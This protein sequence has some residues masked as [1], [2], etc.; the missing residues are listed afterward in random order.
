MNL[1]LFFRS[2]YSETVRHLHH[3]G[4]IRHWQGRYLS[5]N[6]FWASQNDT[7][8]Q[9]QQQQLQP[10][11]NLYTYWHGT[12]TNATILVF[13]FLYNFQ[14]HC[15]ASKVQHVEEAVQQEWFRNVL[16]VQSHDETS[17]TSNILD[18]H[19]SPRPYDAIVVLSHMDCVDDLLVHVLLPSIRNLTRTNVPIQFLAGHSHRR[20]FQSFDHIQ[21]AATFEA[22]RYL[23]TIGFASFALPT[24]VT[25][26]YDFAV[27]L[28]TSNDTA[29]LFDP[30]F[31]HAYLDANRQTLI[32]SIQQ[33]RLRQHATGLRPTRKQLG[34]NRFEF[35]TSEGRA[36]SH[37]IHATQRSL[38]LRTVLGVSPRTYSISLG[39]F[40]HPNSLWGL[41][42]Y[43][44]IPSQVFE[45]IEA[46]D[47][48]SQLRKAFIQ[49]TG[50]F[51]Y[52][53]F[54]GEV[55]LDD[56]IAVCPFNDT[57]YQVASGVT[58]ASLVN[59]LGEFTV[60]NADDNTTTHSIPSMPSLGMTPLHIDL[61]ALYALY[62]PDFNMPEMKMR[63]E[64]VTGETYTPQPL[65]AANG[66]RITT[67][68]AWVTFVQTT[69]SVNSVAK[70]SE[71]V[72]DFSGRMETRAVALDD[73]TQFPI[74][75][76]Q[77]TLGL[78]TLWIVSAALVV[79]WVLSANRKKQRRRRLYNSKSV[80][81]STL[82]L[83]LQS[84]PRT[85]R[86]NVVTR[87]Q[88]LDSVV[89]SVPSYGALDEYR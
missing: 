34:R 24:K 38:G 26:E 8:D 76:V 15:Q 63:L 33:E 59:A 80:E 82:S 49:R 58:G 71:R 75:Q 37:L 6:S 86:G 4:F 29:T 77:G 51:R 87:H 84:A 83:Q 44:V 64:A 20:C 11:G 27:T 56:V 52:N 73:Q 89:K 7:T 35:D 17:A 50:A 43:Q 41:Y 9:Q 1:T 57:I 21:Q 79:G 42:L 16:L 81:N 12:Y 61:D 19:M 31:G 74:E 72:H 10:L 70:V 88:G 18:N 45:T 40:E 14:G 69:W 5:S 67:T 39:D 32:A 65:V 48:K 78:G 46:N 66:Q 85:V 30:G 60:P 62:V 13:G 55:C 28:P 47:K 54:Q 2:C 3:S 25:H 53:L 36:L 23:D 22:G 68:N